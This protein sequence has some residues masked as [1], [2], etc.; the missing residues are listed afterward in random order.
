MLTHRLQD[1]V[2]EE[3]LAAHAFNLFYLTVI[4]LIF[5]V[6]KILRGMLLQFTTWCIDLNLSAA[7]PHVTSVCRSVLLAAPIVILFFGELFATIL[8]QF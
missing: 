4:T 2:V 6:V 7:P 5:I 3:D 8:A 1:A